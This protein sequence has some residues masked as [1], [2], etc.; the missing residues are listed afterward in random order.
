M[1]PTVAAGILPVL[2]KGSIEDFLSMRTKSSEAA[3]AA[4]LKA[5]VCGAIAVM[6]VEAI[7]TEKRTLGVI[8]VRRKLLK[9]LCQ[10]AN[11]ETHVK[12]VPMLSISPREIKA[13]PCQYAKPIP[14]YTTKYS[15]P[16]IKP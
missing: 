12:T 16:N 2:A 13:I 10:K 4:R 1:T 14:A 7:I 11:H 15:A 8:K 5:T 6:V 9:M 3:L